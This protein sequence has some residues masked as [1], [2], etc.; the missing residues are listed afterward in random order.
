MK[1]CHT[2]IC[3]FFLTLQ[4]GDTGEPR[5]GEEG[6]N[7][8]VE[9]SS[10]SSGSRRFFCK[11]TCEGENILIETTEDRAQRG[12][13][14]IQYEDNGHLSY[15]IMYVSIT[16][17]KK[18]DSGKYRCQTDK[19]WLGT[20][21][22]DFDLIVTEAST[23]SEP[24]WTPSTSPSTF[25]SSASLTTT[26]LTQRLSSSSSSSSS[27]TS[28]QTRASTGPKDLLLYVVLIIAVLIFM[29][30]AALLI[31]FRRKR[32]GR[33]KTPPMETDQADTP[34]ESVIYEEIREEDRDNK[35]SPGEISTVYANY[36]NPDGAE[37]TAIY[38]L[39]DCPQNTGEND[40]KEYSEGHLLNDSPSL[41]FT[42]TLQQ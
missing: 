32:F 15:N 22:D 5:R 12:R 20:Q 9:C 26:T 11:E 30:A 14:S 3:F 39:A 31:F 27:T 2:L 36:C 25:L 42:I 23:S 7:I 21:Y 1:V 33:Q 28:Q 37:S 13:Y 29:S 34:K 4:D 6:T 10:I 38:S 8:T 35:P 41:Y 19:T 17:L 16:G 40:E 18:S 24:V